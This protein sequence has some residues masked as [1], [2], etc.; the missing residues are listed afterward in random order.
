[1]SITQRQATHLGKLIN[2]FR[3]AAIADSWK[4]SNEMREDRE[5]IEAE[6]RRTHKRLCDY[7]DKLKEG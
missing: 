4:G 3:D 7:I 1:M 6:L 5:Q 2:E